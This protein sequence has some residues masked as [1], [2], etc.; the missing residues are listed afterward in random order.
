[1]KSIGLL[2]LLVGRQWPQLEFFGVAPDP[3]ALATV[4][5][6]LAANRVPW[7]AWPLPVLWCLIG[8]TTSFLM[9]AA[10]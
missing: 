10:R 4:G 3:T 6:L 1:M 9:S 8:G 7:A 5:L 2:G